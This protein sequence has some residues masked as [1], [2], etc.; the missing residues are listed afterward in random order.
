MVFLENL[1]D[2]EGLEKNPIV[3]WTDTYC[4]E[5]NLEGSLGYRTESLTPC[6]LPYILQSRQEVDRDRKVDVDDI[7]TRELMYLL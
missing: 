1:V 3:L 6:G 5:S 4:M 2:T 7:P